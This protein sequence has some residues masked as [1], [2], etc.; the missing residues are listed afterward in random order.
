MALAIE[1]GQGAGCA[2]SGRLGYLMLLANG[3]MKTDLMF[4]AVCILT[5][6]TIALRSLVGWGLKKMEI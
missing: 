3:R 2:S 4:A 1:G 6:L 5:L